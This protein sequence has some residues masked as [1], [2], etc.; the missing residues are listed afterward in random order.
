MSCATEVL[1]SEGVRNR[2]YE[3]RND[4]LDRF[5]QEGCVRG[6]SKVLTINVCDL[7]HVSVSRTQDGDTHSKWATELLES[8][9]V[10]NRSYESRGDTIGCG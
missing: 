3:S 9:G 2:S 1:E 5:L 4:T 8:E 10:R 7:C 6:N